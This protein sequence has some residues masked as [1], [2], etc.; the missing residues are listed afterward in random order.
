MV[1]RQRKEE[2]ADDDVVRDDVGE[3]AAADDRFVLLCGGLWIMWSTGAPWA[4]SAPMS[5][6]RLGLVR[7][8]SPS[9][10][11]CISS[12]GPKCQCEGAKLVFRLKIII[13]LYIP[14]Q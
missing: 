7:K 10:R 2:R 14:L 8:C 11:I 12:P 9:I 3:D 4:M 6:R 5:D 1:V 13:Y